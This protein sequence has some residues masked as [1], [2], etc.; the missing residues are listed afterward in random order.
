MD[1]N[2][3]KQ[4][5]LLLFTHFASAFMIMCFN[6]TSLLSGFGAVTEFNEE[7][8]VNKFFEIKYFAVS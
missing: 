8:I 3:F 1:D 6:L 2:S 4:L 7:K 5:I